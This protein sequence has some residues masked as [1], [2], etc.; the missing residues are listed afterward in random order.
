MSTY[1]EAANGTFV[2]TSKSLS[3]GVFADV[4]HPDTQEIR[5]FRTI[6]SQSR[7]H[8]QVLVQPSLRRAVFIATEINENPGKRITNAAEELATQLVAAFTFEPEQTRF[9]E[10][11]TRESYEAIND[12]S[13]DEVSLDW[14]GRQAR[15]PLLETFAA[16]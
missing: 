15:K 1:K 13:Y 12:A 11:Y 14:Q 4:L 7:C 9:I 8:L 10:Y 2:Y 5:P 3:Y 6:R 16:S